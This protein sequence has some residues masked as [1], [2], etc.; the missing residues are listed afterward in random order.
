MNLILFLYIAAFFSLALGEFG[1]FPF[2]KT[3]FSIAV[4]DI[5]LTLNLS[6]VLI[7]NVAIKKNLKLPRN[8]LLLI[9][10]WAIGMLSLFFSLDLSGW[11]YLVRFIIYSSTFYLTYH[12]VRSGIL[13]SK[14][15]LTLLKITSVTLAVLGLL[16]LVIFSDLE[17]LSDLGYDPHK[18][19]IF[20]TFLDPNL[21]G[22]FL[23]F[24]FVLLIYELILKPFTNFK[25]FIIENRWGVIWAI[26][27]GSTIVLTFSRSAYLMTV[28]ALLIIL[29]VKNRKLLIGFSILAIILYFVFPAFNARIQ[30]A[31]NID[32]SAQAR[33]ASWDKGLIIF[34]QNPI[35]GAGFNNLRNYS[36]RLDLVKLYSPDGGNSGSGVDS[37][38]IFVLATTGLMGFMGYGLFIIRI[39]ID[40]VASATYD[41]K[42]FY[43]LQLWPVIFRPLMKVFDLPRLGIWQREKPAEIKSQFLSL[44][45]L[46]LTL[47]LVANSFFINSLFF[48][49]IMFL[50]FSLLGVFL[51]SQP[52]ARTASSA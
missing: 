2:G 13:N 10:F 42:Y 7:W 8:F 31:V 3:D 11:L 32:K 35:L 20:S 12:L 47:G 45:L 46:T 18:Y 40:L 25:E 34:Q 51:G 52:E 50:W 27:L 39:L 29:A 33:F 16:Q 41:V 21:L 15:S 49:P 38:L 43:N 6:A 4:T 37:S 17:M 14:E 19:R 26:I 30:G 28:V 44:P 22:T 5:L 1:Q 23:N 48:P 9:I 24:G 36:S